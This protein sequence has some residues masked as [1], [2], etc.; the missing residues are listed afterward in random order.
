MPNTKK[1]ESVIFFF[2][3]LHIILICFCMP[4]GSKIRLQEDLDSERFDFGNIPVPDLGLDWLPKADEGVEPPID[5]RYLTP[6]V[7]PTAEKYILYD[8]AEDLAKNIEVTPGSR[9]HAIV[10]GNFIFGDFIEA[11]MTTRNVQATEMTVAT[12]SLSQDNVDSFYHLM[13]THHIEHL[14]LVISSYFYGN[15]R[16]A[17]IPYIY[18]SLDSLGDGRFQ[19]AVA[20]TH[21]KT[22]HFKTLG[23]KHIIIHGSAN[24]RSSGNIEQFCIEESKELYDFYEEVYS[25]IIEKY[26][27]INQELRCSSLWET[28]SQK[29]FN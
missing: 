13:R 17:L 2:I 3:L 10:S 8:N 25:S 14:N 26:K 20:G 4:K 19:M 15:E 29:Q 5:T 11:F 12:L 7:R 6:R 9:H 23:G 28:I 18:N 1:N 21:T 27:T 24:L 16:H 22:V